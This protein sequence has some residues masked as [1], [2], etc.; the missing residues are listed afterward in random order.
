MAK[1]Q[2]GKGA[3]VNVRDTPMGQSLSDLQ[4]VQH[5]VHAGLTVRCPKHRSCCTNTVRLRFIVFLIAGA[6]PSVYDIYEPEQITACTSTFDTCHDRTPHFRNLPPHGLSLLVPDCTS[7]RM[8]FFSERVRSSNQLDTAR[9]R[10]AFVACPELIQLDSSARFLDYPERQLRPSVAP[11]QLHTERRRKGLITK[12]W[13]H[14]H[15]YSRHDCFVCRA[16]SHM[17]L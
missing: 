16:G 3:S 10:F 4:N 15:W 11:E 13:Y 17:T 1:V 8:Q 9:R 12:L 2:D 6:L 14:D 7:Y 5:G